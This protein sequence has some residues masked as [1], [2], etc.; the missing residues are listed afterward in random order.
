MQTPTSVEQT[1]FSLLYFVEQNQTMVVEQN[2]TI[3]VEQTNVTQIR[4]LKWKDSTQT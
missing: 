1:K 3:P 2:H 4:R